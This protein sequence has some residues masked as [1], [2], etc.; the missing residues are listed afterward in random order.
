[1]CLYPLTVTV[2]RNSRQEL[3]QRPWR[4]AACWLAR[5]P[6]LS[7]LVVYTATCSGQLLIGKMPQSGKGIFSIEVTFSFLIMTRIC[8]EQTKTDRHT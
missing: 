6:W 4:D 3:K 5:S 2:G 1:M 7:R 8:V